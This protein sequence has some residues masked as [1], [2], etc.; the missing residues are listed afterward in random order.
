MNE[1]V[2]YITSVIHVKLPGIPDYKQLLVNFQHMQ[3]PY[4]GLGFI[5]RPC[6]QSVPVLNGFNFQ[7]NRDE[8]VLGVFQKTVILLQ[9]V[10]QR[11]VFCGISEE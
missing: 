4:L 9:R 5:G 8:R 10:Y 2:V 6:F 7:D 11:L 3:R 1:N